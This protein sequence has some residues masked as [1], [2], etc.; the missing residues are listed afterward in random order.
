MKFLGPYV[1][2]TLFYTGT[3]TEAQRKVPITGE[4]FIN[5]DDRDRIVDY[6]KFCDI[7]L[8]FEDNGNIFVWRSNLTYGKPSPYINSNYRY[9]I[10]RGE[11]PALC[12]Y[13]G[14]K[15]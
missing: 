10:K 13:E 12:R 15:I 8:V 11:S 4:N 5:L 3:A 7:Y 9:A 6:S 1:K 14:R 2:K